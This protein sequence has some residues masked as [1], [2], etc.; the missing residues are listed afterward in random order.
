M[1]PGLS[2]ERAPPLTV[3]LRFLLTAPWFACLAGLLLAW[4]GAPLFASRWMPALLAVVHLLTLGFMAQAMLGALLQL[5]AVVGGVP[6]ARTGLV[7]ALTWPAL[8]LGTP[9][10]AA[11]FVLASPTFLRWATLLLGAGFAI[12]LG[13]VLWSFVVHRARHDTAR[14]M[15]LGLLALTI[16]VALGVLLAAALAHGWAVPLIVLTNVHATW[17]LVGWTVILVLAAALTVVPMFQ[18][19][20]DYP[21]I[22]GLAFAPV[23]FLALIAW[24]AGTVHGWRIAAQTGAWIAAA[25]VTAWS[26][27]TLWLQQHGR[28]RNKPDATFLFWRT[29]LLCLLAAV[30]VWAL[31]G[32]R[33]YGDDA[34]H[35]LLLGVLLIPGFAMALICG[36]LY[37]IVPFMLWLSLQ[38]KIGG[39][40]PSVQQILPMERA[41]PQLY[42]HLPALALLLIAAAGVPWLVRPAGVLLALSGAWLGVNLARAALFTH[43]HLR[44]AQRLPAGQG[45]PRWRQ[46]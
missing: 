40:P 35:A 36:M 11:G 3:P 6:V 19:T 29:G 25:A 45:R 37:K 22:V 16:T 21:R 34:R 14:A 32:W 15:L 13:F 42:V 5:L 28:R 27:V 10:L 12:Y 30:V 26:V 24:T 8:T 7:A 43:R 46:L 18:M 1:L 17:G 31:G 20:R 38:M 9:L 44:N 41:M 4:S 33:G 23:I 39:R 2:L